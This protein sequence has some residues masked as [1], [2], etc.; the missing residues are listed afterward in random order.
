MAIKSVYTIFIYAIIA[1][2]TEI[3]CKQAFL[4]KEQNE[5]AVAKWTKVFDTFPEGISIVRNGFITYSNRSLKDIL[6]ISLKVGDGADTVNDALKRQMMETKI[7]P[8]TTRREQQKN[9]SSATTV[10]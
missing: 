3:R 8:Y 5:K 2:V 7:V 4:G 1:Y 9:L 6:E 10:W